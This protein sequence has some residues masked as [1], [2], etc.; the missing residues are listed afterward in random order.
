M[1]KMRTEDKD[2]TIKDKAQPIEASEDAADVEEASQEVLR[3]GGGNVDTD[4][5]NLLTPR[6]DSDKAR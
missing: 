3:S 6:P 4:E 1:T 5:E 2:T